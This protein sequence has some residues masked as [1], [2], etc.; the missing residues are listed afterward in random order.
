MKMILALTVL[1]FAQAG[2][3]MADN[4]GQGPKP[5]PEPVAAAPVPPSTVFYVESRLG[6]V[7]DQ[8]TA[9]R[10]YTAAEQRVI[11]RRVDAMYGQVAADR[12]AGTLQTRT[13]TI[14]QWTGAFGIS[15][16]ETGATGL[17]AGA[18]YGLSDSADIWTV[19]GVSESQH[20]S[21]GAGV[22]FILR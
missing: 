11:S 5:K 7:Y 17:S 10:A 14:G 8:I 4:N 22:S 16:D 2:F 20:I 9:S 3:A 1:L 6:Q 19:I 18:R 21:W 12:A 13:P 15:G